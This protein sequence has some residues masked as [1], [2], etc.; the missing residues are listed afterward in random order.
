VLAVGVLAPVVSLNVVTLLTAAIC[1]GGTFMVMTMAGFQ[2][3]RRLSSGSPTRLIAAM[4]AAFAF[5]QLAGPVAVALSPSGSSTFVL[6]SMAAALL[7]ACSAVALSLTRRVP[8]TAPP[9][10]NEGTSP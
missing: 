1:V 8:Q 7:L 4:T 5:G 2:E 6:P 9:S 3:A 10:P